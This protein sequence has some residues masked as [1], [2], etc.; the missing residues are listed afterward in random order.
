LLCVGLGWLLL[1]VLNRT[2]GKPVV[3][4]RDRIFRRFTGSTPY[5]PSD[6]PEGAGGPTRRIGMRT[7]AALLRRRAESRAEEFDIRDKK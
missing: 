5:G 7:D 1:L 3:A 6:S 2:I 4:A